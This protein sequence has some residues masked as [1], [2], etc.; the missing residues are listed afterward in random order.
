MEMLKIKYAN[1]EIEVEEGTPINIL[2]EEE[3]NNEDIIACVYNNE[4]KSLNI[5]ITK[6]GEIS[7][8][9]YADL[10][11]KRIYNRG[12]IYIMTMAIQEL[13]PDIKLSVNYQLGSAMYCEIEN[14]TI[15]KEFMEKVTLKMREIV[16]KDYLIE[17]VTLSK[18]Q[19]QKFY[20][21]NSTYVGK[22]QLH[23][24]VKDEVSFYC[25][26]GFFN[27]LYGI[28]PIKTGILRTFEIEK[29]NNG[30]LLYFPDMFDM[31]KITR[32]KNTKKLYI[33]LEEYDDIN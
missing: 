20:D 22:L 2:F 5:L 17:K 10:E 29:Y 12:I 3:I 13:Y 4:V 14:G 21:N 18:E 26:N 6:S 7:L 31:N 32:N 23:Y 33:T 8:L 30:F 19:A 1:E 25:C 11:G 27:Y 15:N 9:K 24:K 28:L 16:E